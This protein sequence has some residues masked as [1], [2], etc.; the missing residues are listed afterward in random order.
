MHVSVL[1]QRNLQRLKGEKTLDYLANLHLEN[2]SHSAFKMDC[3]PPADQHSHQPNYSVLRD[4]LSLLKDLGVQL[5][6]HSE[7][8]LFQIYLK[9][10]IDYLRFHKVLLQEIPGLILSLR[11]GKVLLSNGCLCQLEGQ[12]FQKIRMMI[13]LTLHL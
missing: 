13:S 8:H 10:V 12:S 6:L 4:I 9:K 2:S 7:L 1:L 11:S 3:L 5:L